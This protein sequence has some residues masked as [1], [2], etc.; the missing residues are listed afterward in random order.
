MDSYSFF[1]IVKKDHQNGSTRILDQAIWATRKTLEQFK[2]GDYFV[3]SILDELEN[4][5]FHHP[6]LI[7]LRHFINQF[8]NFLQVREN[9]GVKE[10]N[11]WIED[12]KKEWKDVN[13]RIANNFLDIVD[14]RQ[15][16]VLLHSHSGTIVE[17]GKAMAKRKLE[18][19]IFQTT[20]E[21]GGEGILQA[22]ELKNM[23]LKVEIISDHEM[24][25]VIPGV[26]LAVF[27]A[28]QISKEKW[29]NKVGT[30]R[31]ADLCLQESKQ[32]WVLCDSRKRV[33]ET[34]AIGDIFEETSM[35]LATGMVTENIKI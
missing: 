18:V 19:K 15:A 30:K 34:Q 32:V 10:A 28:D 20:S 25:Q 17:L 22:A 1:D 7:I 3:I 31:I 26:D 23:G 6:D 9:P 5:E 11:Q 29:T 27:G 4:L 2:E 21:P 14:L 8:K 35:A 13:S 33:E 12:Y 24:A 16:T